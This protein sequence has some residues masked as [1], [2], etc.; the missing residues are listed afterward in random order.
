MRQ[1]TPSTGGEAGGCLLDPL[2]GRGERHPDVGR[3]GCAVEGPR[4]DEDPE[5]GEGVD[6][7]P[8]DGLP[9]RGTGGDIGCL[10][11]PA[12][13]GKIADMFGG[14]IRISFIFSLAFPAIMIV[15]LILLRHG[16]KKRKKSAAARAE[17]EE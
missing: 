6:G 16:D 5:V 17:C 12:L 1:V 9:G 14:D 10:V 3:T 7:L 15:S 4:C 2:V 8:R 13:V 11:G